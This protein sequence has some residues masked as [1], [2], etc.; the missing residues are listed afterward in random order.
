MAGAEGR[1]HNGGCILGTPDSELKEISNF[2]ETWAQAHASL[3]LGLRN[4]SLAQGAAQQS[5]KDSNPRRPKD[6]HKMGKFGIPGKIQILY[7]YRSSPQS[8]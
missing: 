1:L 4:G 3:K 8:I 5:L 2:K 7:M 6:P